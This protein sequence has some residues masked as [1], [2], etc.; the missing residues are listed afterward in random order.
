MAL[1]SPDS[2]DLSKLLASPR[3]AAK[4]LQAERTERRDTSAM[5]QLV[6]KIGRGNVLENYVIPGLRS[7]LL[8]KTEKGGVIRIFDMLR[9]Q[10]AGITPHNHRYAFDCFVLSGEVKQ[11]LY[12]VEPAD[13]P[14]FAHYAKLRY[15]REQ[16][17]LVGEPELLVGWTEERTYRQGEWYGM[18]TRQ[19]HSIS[20]A[21]GSSVLF[22][23]GPIE[24]EDV[25]CIV[26]YSA[27]RVCDTLEWRDWMMGEA[28]P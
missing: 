18:T 28:T 4:S 20:F 2:F 3:A 11:R 13:E 27:G 17:K 23:E 19:Y 24:R 7:T 14:K 22:I 12:R 5:Y 21:E 16:R 15:D 6:E 26:P 10:E 8:G 9:D 25:Y 1:M